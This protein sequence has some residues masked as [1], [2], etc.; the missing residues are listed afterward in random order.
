MCEQLNVAAF[1]WHSWAP[2]CLPSLCISNSTSAATQ[3]CL[4]PNLFHFR[5]SR[6]P[7]VFL[8]CAQITLPTRLSERNGTL[9][10]NLYCKLSSNCNPTSGI[11][12]K[13]FSDHQ[14]YVTFLHNKPNYTPTPRYINSTTYKEEAFT[15]LAS[16][17]KNTHT[18]SNLNENPTA[19]PNLSYIFFIEILQS[20]KEKHLP[21][22]LIRF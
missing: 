8:V 12:I 18:W 1:L 19:D 21:S 11:L 2:R 10:D 7:S 22:K 3:R 14:P 6:Y 16:E 9:I 20:A 17:L 15:N 5:H 13:K 4:I